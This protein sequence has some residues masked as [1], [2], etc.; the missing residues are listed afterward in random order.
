M[1]AVVGKVRFQSQRIVLR[2]G[3]NDREKDCG[4]FEEDCQVT[5][6]GSTYS[7]NGGED[8]GLAVAVT[9]SADSQVDLLGTRVA[10]ERFGDT[11]ST[12]TTVSFPVDVVP[13]RADEVLVQD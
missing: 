4:Q 9:V 11:C 3:S 6:R 7:T 1:E 12:K 8:V 2:G 10:L 5:E 13:G